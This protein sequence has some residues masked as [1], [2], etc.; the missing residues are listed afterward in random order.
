MSD[1]S[2][3]Y[4]RFNVLG[5]GVSR[6]NLDSARRAIIEAVRQGRK[7]YV[8]VTGVHGV[9]EAQ[10]DREFNRILNR[11]YLNTP[12][13][14]PLVWLGKCRFGKRVSR[15]Y[16]PDLML[17]I[18]EATRETGATHYFY[19]GKPGVAKRLSQ[20]LEARFPGLQVRGSYAPPFRD[21]TSHE[22]RELVEEISR[23]RPDLFWVGLST[24]KQERF[25]AAFL[26]KL[27]T[28]LMLG[29]GAA[30]DFH[31]D[32]V[33]Q[34]PRW[35]QRSGFEWLFRLFQEPRRLSGRYL[36]NNPLF[37]FRLLQQLSGL[38]KYPIER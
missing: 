36:R 22:E 3:E 29:V 30:F 11:A 19:G 17:G 8:C 9:C 4:P 23:L 24:P 2:I 21:L 35:I 7:G 38:K 31:S 15:V 12:D 37:L 27:T 20:R 1:E 28:T 16:G 34:A 13:G 10:E 25:M 6:I 32:E 26:P 5:V 33:R 14:M 18:C